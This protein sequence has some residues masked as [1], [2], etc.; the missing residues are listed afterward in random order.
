MHKTTIPSFYWWPC[1]LQ[2]ITDSFSDQSP[3]I[4]MI[5]L[6]LTTLSIDMPHTQ[7][8][9]FLSPTQA[10]KLWKHGIKANLLLCIALL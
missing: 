4:R 9:R 3:L 5:N 8:N 10:S 7:G 6:W 1:V 2:K